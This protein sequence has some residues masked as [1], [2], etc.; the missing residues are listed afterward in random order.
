[1]HRIWKI[2]GRQTAAIL[3]V[4]VFIT[5]TL[6]VGRT[7]LLNENLE[8]VA[9]QVSLDAPAVF[10]QTVVLIAGGIDISVGSV[11]AMAAA[12]AIGLQPYGTAT[13]VLLALLFGL[14]VG[15]LNGLLVTK[16]RI[17][18]FVATLGT[19]SVIRGALLTYTHQAPLSGLD[20]NF[21]WWGG[22][23]IGIVPIPLLITLALLLVLT[24]FLRWTRAGRNFYAIGGNREAAYLAGIAVLRCEF[25][26]YAISGTLAALGGVLLASRLNSA[27]VQLG[28][29]TALLSISAALVGGASLLGGRGRITGAFLGVLALGML[30][31]GMDLLGVQ[32]YYQIA[33]R[34]AI[35]IGVVALDAFTRN[36]ARRLAT[37]A[38]AGAQLALGGDKTN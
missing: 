8:N 32:T 25:L 11:M 35:L 2:G 7:F 24:G 13:A 30:T 4:G 27:T 21:A 20:D 19:M 5:F 15:A 34:A 9:R 33:I 31:N 6:T 17:L 38:A 12:L 22:G 10:G 37:S 26:A 28:N 3:V 36:F 16:G 18:P 23:S 14:M 29:D 1:M